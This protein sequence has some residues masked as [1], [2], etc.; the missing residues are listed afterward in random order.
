MA[1]PDIIIMGFGKMAADCATILIDNGVAVQNI[2]ETEHSKFSTLEGFTKRLNIPYAKPTGEEIRAFLHSLEKPTVVFSINNNYIFPQRICHKQNLRIVN[3]HNSLL[4]RYPGHGRVIPSWVIFNGEQ[5][6]GVTW[7]LV[8]ADI[9]AGN[10]LCQAHFELS[11]IDTAWKLMMRCISLGIE[12]FSLHWQEFISPEYRGRPQGK[13]N[14]RIFGKNDIPNQGELI[15]T[16]DFNT[17]GN[18]L[19]CMDYGVF[20]LLPQ[21]KIHLNSKWYVVKSYKVESK[22]NQSFKRAIQVGQTLEG[23][24]SDTTMLYPEGT[25]KLS[26]MQEN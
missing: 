12:L 21:P 13:A 25:I 24:P 4:P 15:L 16:W 7:H 19:R 6:H 2:W 9:D 5:R 14:G 22:A 26:I 20:K 8:S 1:F 17:A 23:K 11:Q 3:F 18:F 10:I